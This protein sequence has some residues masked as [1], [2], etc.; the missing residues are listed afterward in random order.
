MPGILVCRG[1]PLEAPSSG[2]GTACGRMISG[3][4]GF[5]VVKKCEIELDR[6]VG[7]SRQH[8]PPGSFVLRS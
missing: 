7:R 1:K 8:S 2:A 6:L 3:D 5:H 4:D